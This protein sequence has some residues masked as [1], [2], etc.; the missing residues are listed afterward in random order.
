[1]TLTPR[2]TPLALRD[3]NEY[4]EY[5]EAR[6]DSVADRFQNA[7]RQTVRMLCENPE[8]G[9]RFR[10]DPTGQIRFRTVSGFTNYLIFYRRVDTVLEIVRVLHGAMDYDKTVD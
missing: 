8:L 2:Y 1:M 7:V 3:V 9:E 6:S 5:F 10:F 4:S